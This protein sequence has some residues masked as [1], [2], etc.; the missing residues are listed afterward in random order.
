MKNSIG[1]CFQD[2]LTQYVAVLPF[3][4]KS[5]QGGFFEG[6][7]TAMRKITFQ[8]T[9]SLGRHTFETKGHE[10]MSNAKQMN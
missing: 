3:E 4:V 1:F 6:A 10:N 5:S 8:Q 7:P 2:L 9:L